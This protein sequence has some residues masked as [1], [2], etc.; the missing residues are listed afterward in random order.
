MSQC[1]FCGG[2]F[3]DDLM[4]DW[5]ICRSCYSEQ[6]RAITGEDVYLDSLG[7]AWTKEELDAAGGKAEVDRLN[8]QA[9]V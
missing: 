2:E 6:M 3:S 9:R 5:T 1:H 8:K 4:A 7:I